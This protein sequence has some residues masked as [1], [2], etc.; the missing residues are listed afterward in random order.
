MS[1]TKPKRSPR[2]IHHGAFTS[3]GRLV[4]FPTCF[5]GASVPITADESLITALDVSMD[6]DVYGGTSG[7]QTHLFVGMF[8]GITGAVFD[9]A[10]IKDAQHC[11]AVCCGRREFAAF[12]N[13]DKG[14]RILIHRLQGLPFDL[15][16]EWGFRR[17][18]CEEIGV[19]PDGGRIIHAAPDLSRQFAVGVSEGHLFVVNLEDK[20]FQLVGAVKGRGRV[21]V[22][23]EENFYGLDTKETLWRFHPSFPYVGT[24]CDPSPKRR[25]DGCGPTMGERSTIRFALHSGL[26]RKPV[27]IR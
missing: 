11:A 12:V 10:A 5:P 8:R 9:M 21:G 17:S 24:P 16:Q 20:S 27:R 14:G 26:R 19:I 22:G 23:S 18:P 4:A 13:G 7:K 2:D 3:E 1:E 25:M 15:I 6:G